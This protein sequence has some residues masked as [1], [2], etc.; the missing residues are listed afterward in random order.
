MPWSD[1]PYAGFSTVEP[2][3]PLNADWARNNAARQA[4]DP[5]SMLSLYQGLLH[6]RRAE[7]ALHCGS[8]RTLRVT[9]ELFIFE[10][11]A[12]RRTLQIA[13][14]IG[15]RAAVE[16]ASGRRLLSTRMLCQ[17]R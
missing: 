16:L 6:L 11:A 14:N 13:L 1:A 4:T 2:W 15:G 5:A 9:D 7:P 8:Y 12:A 17:A 10:R 3:L